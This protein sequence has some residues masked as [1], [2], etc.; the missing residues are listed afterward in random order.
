MISRITSRMIDHARRF[1][2]DPSGSAETV[3]FAVWT[4]VL[5]LTLATSLEIGVYTARAT[6]L[7]RGLDL[8]VRDVRL[9]TGSA[10]Q[11][12]QIKTMICENAA[13]IPNCQENL[14]LEMM[15]RDVRNWRSIPETADCTDRALDAAPVREFTA[16]LEN[17]LMVLRACAKVSPILPMTWFSGA[18]S[19]D[20]AGDYAIITMSTFVQEPR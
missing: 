16:G 7:E 8:A 15:A 19:R 20:S 9:G 3:S 5:L 13:L 11:H 17:E 18:L 14:R 2:R 12:D 6:M 1:L 4:P 10:P